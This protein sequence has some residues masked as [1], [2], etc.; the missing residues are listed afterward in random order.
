[1][2]YQHTPDM[3]LSS[4]MWQSGLIESPCKKLI[5]IIYA[6]IPYRYYRRP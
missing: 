5:H 3:A 1:M 6:A 4:K 2:L